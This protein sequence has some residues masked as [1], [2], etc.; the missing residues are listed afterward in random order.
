MGLGEGID[1]FYLTGILVRGGH[2]FDMFLQA[3]HELAGWMEA[4]L[5]HNKSL[6]NQPPDWIYGKWNTIL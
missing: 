3:G 5:Q 2:R 1:K 4:G 6:D